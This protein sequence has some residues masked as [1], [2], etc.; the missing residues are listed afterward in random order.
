VIEMSETP[1]K[2]V[3]EPVP[4][5]EPFW[6]GLRHHV[7]RIQYS[8]SSGRFVFYP[9]LLAPLTLADDLEWREVSGRGSLYTFSTAWRPTA[10][11]WSSEVPQML[12]IVELDEGPRLSAPLVSVSPA[13][14]SVGMRV[15][16]VFMD[17]PQDITVLAYRPSAS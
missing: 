12:G 11:P 5:S 6:D 9:R 10:P 3:P 16:P 14:L 8:P 15:T 7:V 4:T 2:P 1:A 13:S 17:L